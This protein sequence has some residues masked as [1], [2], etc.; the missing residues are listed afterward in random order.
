[1]D[2]EPVDLQTSMVRFVDTG[3]ILNLES[4]KSI[5]GWLNEK[6]EIIEKAK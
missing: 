3:V 5:A 1:V 2:K 6:I 4:A